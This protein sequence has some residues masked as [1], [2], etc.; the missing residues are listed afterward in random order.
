MM[1]GRMGERDGAQM[2][3]ATRSTMPL[4]QLAASAHSGRLGGAIWRRAARR[5][6]DRTQSRVTLTGP[7]GHD[8]GSDEAT[9]LGGS[10]L[11]GKPW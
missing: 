5:A 6:R 9:L 1:D 7:G 8:V 3:S 11:H 10:L 2:R 4:Q